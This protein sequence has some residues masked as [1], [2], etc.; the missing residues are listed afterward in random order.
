VVKA[1]LKSPAFRKNNLQS[2]VDEPFDKFLR[3]P[4]LIF[5]SSIKTHQII[6]TE[7]LVSGFLCLGI[8][9]TNTYSHNCILPIPG[10]DDSLACVSFYNE[11]LSEYILYRKFVF[12]HLWF[13]NVRK[14]NRLIGFNE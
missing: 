2:F 4:G 11:L 1:L 5:V 7:C 12:V 3:W 6:V 13:V 9:D 8:L 14:K 10:N